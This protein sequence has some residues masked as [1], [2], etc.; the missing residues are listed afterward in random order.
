MDNSTKRDFSIYMESYKKQ[1]FK[2]QLSKTN[3]TKMFFFVHSI[4]MVNLSLDELKTIVKSRSI[5][6]AIKACLK[7]DY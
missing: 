4:K 2:K 6:R 5:L 3:S 7:E 1:S